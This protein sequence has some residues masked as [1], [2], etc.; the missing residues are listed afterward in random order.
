MK[1]NEGV[2]E[3]EKKAAHADERKE[4][5]WRRIRT[6]LLP[7]L[8]IAGVFTLMLSLIALVLSVAALSKT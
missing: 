5:I 6:D 1:G 4:R 3:R 7:W 8:F 2:N